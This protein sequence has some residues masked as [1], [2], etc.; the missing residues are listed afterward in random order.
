VTVL[1]VCRQS[2]QKRV[3]VYLSHMVLC[4]SV[5]V[6]GS[7]YAMT[8]QQIA[9][10]M[11]ALLHDE[12]FAIQEPAVVTA[13]LERYKSGKGDLADYLIC[14]HAR[15]R[16]AEPTYTFDKAVHSEPGFRKE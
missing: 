3:P 8:R 5:W 14:L 15:Y 9:L 10:A 1:K 16:E 13:A 6:L 4:E 2:R 11:E 12:T 7:L